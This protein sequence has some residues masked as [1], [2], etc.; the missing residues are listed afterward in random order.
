MIPSAEGTSPDS[1]AFKHARDLW[2]PALLSEDRP[3]PARCPMTTSSKL[4]H[5]EWSHSTAP[6]QSL[7]HK[8]MPSHCEQA[9]QLSQDRFP[10]P[11]AARG[12][13][14][15]VQASAAHTV[16]WESETEPDHA[17]NQQPENTDSSFTSKPLSTSWHCKA[18][19]FHGLAVVY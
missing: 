18:G 8:M 3:L 19:I 16:C 12:D 1:S 4:S 11:W 5:S 10:I 14:V 6:M 9:R 7:P 13:T 2:A 17:W 15:P